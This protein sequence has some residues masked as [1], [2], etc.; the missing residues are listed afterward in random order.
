MEFPGQR[1]R[2]ALSATNTEWKIYDWKKEKEIKENIQRTLLCALC[3]KPFWQSV[4]SRCDRGLC[5]NHLATD[6]RQQ[7]PVEEIHLVIMLV[8]SYSWRV[9]CVVSYSL[10]GRTPGPD[11]CWA[12]LKDVDTIA[13]ERR[14]L[15][16]WPRISP[17]HLFLI[18]R[19]C[20]N[21]SSLAQRL[22][23]RLLNVCTVYFCM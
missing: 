10:L 17:G 14:L 11:H 4:C 15:F 6:K 16:P 22:C 8:S 18:H 7:T 1:R 9:H 13:E 5:T 21:C 2:S 20:F 23:R 19:F 3:A 12:T